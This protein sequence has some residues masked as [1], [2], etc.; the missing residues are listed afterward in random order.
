MHDSQDLGQHYKNNVLPLCGFQQSA[1][2]LSKP[3]PA[4]FVAG[5]G[6]E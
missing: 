2:S 1:G 3:V 6:S 4:M 5:I